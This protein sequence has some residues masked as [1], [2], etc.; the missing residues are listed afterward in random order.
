M[1][2]N[3][4]NI[5]ANKTDTDFSVSYYT[6]TRNNQFLSTGNSKEEALAN[7]LHELRCESDNDY[8]ENRIDLIEQIEKSEMFEDSY[9]ELAHFEKTA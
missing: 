2:T 3:Y 4:K 7:Y 5:E 9:N 1:N 6:L 8:D